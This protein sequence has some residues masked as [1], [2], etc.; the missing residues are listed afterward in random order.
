ML[1][2]LFLAN[3]RC[4][5]KLCTNGIPSPS[6]SIAH[7]PTALPSASRFTNAGMFYSH[8][9]SGQPGPITRI[10]CCTKEEYDKLPEADRDLV[11]TH[12]AH[13]YTRHP[14]NGDIYSAYNKPVAIIDWLAKNDVKEEY[15]L[16]IDADM[17]MREPFTPEV[18][19]TGR[20][21]LWWGAG[22][23]VDAPDRLLAASGAAWRPV[24]Q[25]LLPPPP[26]ATGGGRQ[27]GPGS[28]GLLWLHEG[29][30]ECAGHEARALGA[31]PQ[32]HHGR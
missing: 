7:W 28:G 26:W 11:P 3:A 30:E 1:S 15:V 24:S 21:V 9:K 5:G 17:I 12:V 22:A 27:A 31:A 13:S 32:R 23:A 16:V 4:G 20:H 18:C 14:R 6:P 10:M 19:R 29:S 8:R 2:L 25:S